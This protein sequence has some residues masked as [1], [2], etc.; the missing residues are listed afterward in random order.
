MTQ[1]VAFASPAPCSALIALIAS[2]E[3]AQR[4]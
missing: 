3:R 2:G 4:R 1:L